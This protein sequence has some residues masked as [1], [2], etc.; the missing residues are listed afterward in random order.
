MINKEKITKADIYDENGILLLSTKSITFPRDFFKLRGLE[1]VSVKGNDLP[2]FHKDDKIKIIFEY[3]NGTRIECMSKVDIS[4][5]QQLNFH[6]GEG[7]VLEERRRSFKVETIEPA[8]IKRIERNEEVL[9]PETAQDATILN[10]N[11]GGVLLKT[12]A[13]LL[14]DDIIDLSIVP[15]PL[16]LRAKILRRQTDISGELVGYGCCFLDVTTIQEEKLA[17]HLLECQLAER[18]RRRNEGR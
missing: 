4:T 5:D 17:R 15:V 16:D 18:E 10:I 8:F 2:I 11:L 3:M 12:D 9:D 13:E 1:L 14:V 7:V 6:V